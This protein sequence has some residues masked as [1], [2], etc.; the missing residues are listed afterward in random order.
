LFGHASGPVDKGL[1]EAVKV[2]V[3]L[4]LVGL[5]FLNFLNTQ[6][7]EAIL[8]SSVVLKTVGW[9]LG[10]LDFVGLFLVRIL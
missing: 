8:E 6:L 4:N 2:C 10:L 5:F 3:K 9:I 7:S 1:L